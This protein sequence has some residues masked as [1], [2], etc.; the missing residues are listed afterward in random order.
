MPGRTKPRPGDVLASRSTA[1]EDVYAIS[2][3]PTG[4]HVVTRGYDAAL[5]MVRSIATRHAVD[6]WYTCD[7]IHF[8][9]VARRRS[10][11]QTE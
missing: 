5:E 1:R 3:M 7:H 10:D 4:A 11:S 6:G 2:V 8:L 9:R